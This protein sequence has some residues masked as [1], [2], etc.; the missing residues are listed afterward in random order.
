MSSKPGSR[1]RIQ[2][3]VSTPSSGQSPST[4]LTLGPACEVLPTQLIQPHFPRPPNHPWRWREKAINPILPMK[5]L[6]LRE[7]Q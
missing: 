1:A 6:R 5:K 4:T 2:S 7:Q 3:Q